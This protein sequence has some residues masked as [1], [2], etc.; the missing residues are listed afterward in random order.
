[1]ERADD[2]ISDDKRVV[3][4]IMFMKTKAILEIV[5]GYGVYLMILISIYCSYCF[6]CIANIEYNFSVVS[7]VT[8]QIKIFATGV[9][10]VSKI[11]LLAVLYGVAMPSLLVV[12]MFKPVYR[13]VPHP[14]RGEIDS[15]EPVRAMYCAL[16]YFVSHGVMAHVMAISWELRQLVRKNYL[17]GFL[18]TRT[19]AD[20]AQMSFFAFYDRVLR[21]GYT[22]IFKSFLINLILFVPGVLLTVIIPLRMGHFFCGSSDPILFRFKHVVTDM[23][24]PVEMLLSHIFIPFLLEKV[25]YHKVLRHSLM[26]ILSTA[27][28]YLSLEWILEPESF[29]DIDFNALE[30]RN[31]A[32]VH[33]PDNTA[34]N[35]PALIEDV[36][37]IEP[38]ADVQENQPAEQSA[39]EIN[40]DEVAAAPQVLPVAEQK[41]AL[42]TIRDL[43]WIWR[44]ALLIIF[45]LFSWSALS[46]WALH[47]P[48]KV[49]SFIGCP[50]GNLIML[51]FRCHD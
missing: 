45:S 13:S 4:D 6:K 12:L 2:L 21:S 32:V 44:M 49:S 41:A 27:G 11:S 15:D 3:A 14:E 16:L 1:M 36:A 37:A 42:N 23:Q 25:Q 30:N 33:I 34:Q 7:I 22:D 47:L 17:V 20:P 18:H 8:N 26:F 48:L 29:P 51:L 43:P 9:D 46:S 39:V 10:A 38:P 35:I 5:I 50:V 31:A 28:Q 40:V 19:E 24:I